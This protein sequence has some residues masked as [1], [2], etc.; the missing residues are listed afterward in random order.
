MK[1]IAMFVLLAAVSMPCF[2]RS[3][4]SARI[5]FPTA[6]KVGTKML[7]Q[8]SYKMVWTGSE[9]QAKVS[10]ILSDDSEESVFEGKPA[11][12]V[13]ATVTS[14]DNTKDT[15]SP[16]HATFTVAQKDGVTILN[17][18]EMPH[19]TLAFSGTSAQ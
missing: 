5:D 19:S 3:R 6:I 7:P 1:S 13:Q 16:D 14:A 9:S 2:A 8:G 4:N 10:F 12:T 18:V 11:V 15:N 17:T